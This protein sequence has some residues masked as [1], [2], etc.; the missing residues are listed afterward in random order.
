VWVGLNAVNMLIAV[1]I[2]HRRL[3][4]HD[5]G[6][7]FRDIGFPFLAAL[8]VAGIARLAFANL[9][10]PVSIFFALLTVG[11]ASLATAALAAPIIRLAIQSSAAAAITIAKVQYSK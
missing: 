4:P 3:L 2:M 8:G 10:S 11:F 1:P 9:N 7:Y 6:G 5:M